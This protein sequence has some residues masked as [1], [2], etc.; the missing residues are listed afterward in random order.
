VPLRHGFAII[1]LVDV[2]AG[3]AIQTASSE[4][5]ASDPDARYGERER[6]AVYRALEA[7]AE[8]EIMQ[9]NL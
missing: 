4:G 1:A 7:D 9:E 2:R 8:I 6:D 3:D 5:P